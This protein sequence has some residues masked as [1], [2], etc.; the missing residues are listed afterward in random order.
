MRLYPYKFMTGMDM[1]RIPHVLF[2]GKIIIFSYPCKSK[3]IFGI[4][5]SFAKSDT[6]NVAYNRFSI[7]IWIWHQANNGQQYDDY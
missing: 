5:H 7:R 3:Y 1:T 2:R 4:K 6:E